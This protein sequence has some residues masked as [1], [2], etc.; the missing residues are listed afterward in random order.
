MDEMGVLNNVHGFQ[1]T[2]TNILCNFV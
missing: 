1:P 2:L